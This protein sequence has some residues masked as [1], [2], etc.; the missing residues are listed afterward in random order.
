MSPFLR[1]G[2]LVVATPFFIVMFDYQTH[3]H[4]KGC[5][6][7]GVAALLL[8]VMIDSDDFTSIA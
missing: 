1:G 7:T 8:I 2:Y 4:M 6:L 3:R 5:P